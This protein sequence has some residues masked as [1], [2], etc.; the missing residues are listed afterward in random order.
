MKNGQSVKTV[1]EQTVKHYIEMAERQHGRSFNMPTIEYFPKGRKGGHANPWTWM[2]GF[3]A[4]LLEDNLQRYMVRT[5]PHEV[6]HLIVFAIHG[7]IKKGSKCVW[8]GEEFKAQMRA[9]GCEETRCHTMDTSKVR[10]A[11]RKTKKHVYVC[12]CGHTMN[13]S[14]VRHN[15]MLRGRA[16]YF[17]KCHTDGS[18]TYTGRAFTS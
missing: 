18:L 15:K 10:Q 11:K 17:H 13:L 16:K 12:E 7:E 4:G 8:H 1:V 6:A 2:V 9:F 3:N 5:I 14:S